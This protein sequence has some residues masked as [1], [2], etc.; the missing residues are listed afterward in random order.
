MVGPKRYSADIDG[1]CQLVEMPPIQRMEGKIK[2]FDTMPDN[3]LMFGHQMNN[4]KIMKIIRDKGII[5][6]IIVRDPRDVV[7]S[8]FYHERSFGK[9]VRYNR[10]R[11][12][13]PQEAIKEVI[14]HV[15][16]PKVNN[17]WVDATN[18]KLN[19]SEYFKSFS[20]FWRSDYVNVIR[21]ED[22]VGPLGGG[23]QEKQMQTL[24]FIRNKLGSSADIEQIASR[25]FG[26]PITFRKGQIGEWAREMSDE[27]KELVNKVAEDVIKEL[28]YE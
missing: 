16:G 15:E 4:E 26:G 18:E 10:F 25:L 27:N 7:I 5:T 11:S 6:F 8:R 2:I 9:C 3:H 19:I 28:G 1:S 20:M 24:R 14:Y 12:I 21:F 13:P 17:V 22:L 23:S